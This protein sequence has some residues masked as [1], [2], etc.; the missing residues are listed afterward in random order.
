MSLTNAPEINNLGMV[1]RAT[2]K[3]STEEWYSTEISAALILD[4]DR[5]LRDTKIRTGG[6]KECMTQ[7]IG[8]PNSASLD[9]A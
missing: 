2:Y 8:D 5:L 9:V 6:F 7:L 3:C 4:V 1:S